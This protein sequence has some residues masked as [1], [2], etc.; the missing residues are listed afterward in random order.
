MQT[1]SRLALLEKDE[2]ARIDAWDEEPN[3]R[4]RSRQRFLNSIQTFRRYRTTQCGF[5]H[6]LAA[7]GNGATDMMLSCSI[8]LS[9]QRIAQLAEYSRPLEL[10]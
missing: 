7:G 3:Y 9:N 1:D 6:S 8:E 5:L 10:R 4:R 2:L